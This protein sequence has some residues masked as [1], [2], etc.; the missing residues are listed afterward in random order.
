MSSFYS[1]CLELQA[2]RDDVHM[3]ELLASIFASALEDMASSESALGVWG[4]KALPSGLWQTMLQP[5]FWL[6]IM[7]L[8]ACASPQNG[9]RWASL[10][11]EYGQK[12]KRAETPFYQTGRLR[13]I[14]F[15]VPFAVAVAWKQHFVGADVRLRRP[16]R[17]PWFPREDRLGGMNIS[18]RSD[19]KEP[20]SQAGPSTKRFCPGP[21][22]FN[23]FR[24]G[25]GQPIQGNVVAVYQPAAAA[26]P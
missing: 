3:E 13:Q 18:Q 19:A 1:A 12:R 4:R 9:N 6:Q 10:K 20:D 14:P 8:N 24:Q 2:I 7:R 26:V 21:G 16:E 25:Q 22:I 11:V 23:A 17:P 15:V 5:I